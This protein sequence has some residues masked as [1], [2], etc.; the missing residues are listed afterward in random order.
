ME[1]N[2]PVTRDSVG[3]RDLAHG[4]EAV[5]PLLEGE[6]ATARHHFTTPKWG[7][8]NRNWTTSLTRILGHDSC[9]KF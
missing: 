7:R 1:Y 4:V 8:L 3:A 6:K 9:R 2:I 5:L